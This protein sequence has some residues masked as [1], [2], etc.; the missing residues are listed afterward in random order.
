[1]NGCQMKLEVSG[2]SAG[3]DALILVSD[4]E[5][6]ERVAEKYPFLALHCKSNAGFFGRTLLVIHDSMP[7]NRLIHAPIPKNSHSHYDDVR[8]VQQIVRGALQVAIESGSKRPF[9]VLNCEP[10][11]LELKA[12]SLALF[13]QAYIPSNQ[14]I[15]KNSPLDEVVLT[16]SSF[17]RQLL[18]QVETVEQ[19]KSLART[20]AGGDPEFMNPI[21]CARQVQSAFKGFANVC[22]ECIADASSLEREYPLLFAV[23]RASLQTPKH[24]PVVVKIRYANVQDRSMVQR[25]HLIGKGITYDTGGADLKV[26]GAMVGMSRDKCGAAT[27]A[28]FML[29]VA[30]AQPVNCEF[31]AYLAFV[32]N[33]IGS[34]SYVSDELLR[35]RSGKIVRVGNTD[36]E[37]RMVMVD[38]IREAVE[39][40]QSDK[41]TKGHSTILTC[42]TL[43]GHACR[44]Y[45]MCGAIVPNSV[46]FENGFARSLAATGESLGEP[47]AISQLRREDFE[48][49]DG[50]GTFCDYHS[51][52]NKPSTMTDRGHQYPGAFLVAASGLLECEVELGIQFAHLDVAAVS[53]EGS[54]GRPTAFPLAT[55]YEVFVNDNQ[56]ENN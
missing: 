55:L 32:R 26:N 48:F 25:V 16:S 15:Q 7:G 47:F 23:G 30:H 8:T 20:I 31:T 42:A 1:M 46:A 56:K 18:R 21:E 24:A 9:L 3:C 50:K 40:C 36:A 6:F 38:L 39:S 52:N 41:N 44:A 11:S 35:A 2:E 49:I 17:S 54:L 45:G 10:K 51:A 13:Q 14:Y 37:G 27:L 5:S 12:I 33:S 28:G 29:S 43:T 19:G 34:N 53:E 22:V 4:G